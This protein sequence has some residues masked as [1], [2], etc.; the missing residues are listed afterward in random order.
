LKVKGTLWAIAVSVLVI[1]CASD[2][3]GGSTPA[4]K[5]SGTTMDKAEGTTGTTA[6]GEGS[7]ESHIA[8]AS[9][10][11]I[12][13]ARC[14]SCHGAQNPPE[15]LSLTSYDS[16]MK[17]GEHGAVV[18]A[19]APADSLLVKMIRGTDGKRMPPKGDPLT[20]EQIETIEHWIADGAKS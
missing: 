13:D 15:G 3:S 16:V 20:A 8:Y 2:T 18:K 7:H 1:G 11:E 14:T 19:G 12:F 9:I 5:D 17:G 10:Q 4:P 6:E